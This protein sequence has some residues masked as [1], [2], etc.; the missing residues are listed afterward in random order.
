M[1]LM[2][3]RLLGGR[4]LDEIATMDR[5]PAASMVAPSKGVGGSARSVAGAAVPSDSRF[6]RDGSRSVLMAAL[7]VLLWEIVAL[8]LQAYR[9]REHAEARSE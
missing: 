3:D 4:L 9:L 1:N 5:G 6:P 8:G 7:L 2:F